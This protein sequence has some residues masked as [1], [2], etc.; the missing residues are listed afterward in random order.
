MP[1]IPQPAPQMVHLN[2]S[3]FKA[4][5]SGKPDEDAETHLL[6]TNDWMNSDHFIDSVRV[7]PICLTLLGKTRLWYQLLEPINVDW[8]GLQNI[9][10]QQYSKICN[11]R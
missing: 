10:R 9:F 8:P 5:F 4:E 3:N 1:Q 11:T 6:H 7:Q 2:L